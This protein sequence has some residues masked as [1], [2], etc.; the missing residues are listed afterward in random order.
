MAEQNNRLGYSIFHGLEQND[1]LIEI[2]DALLHNCFLQLFHIGNI[3]PK[4][5]YAEDSLRFA[6]LLSKSV[7]VPLSEMHHSLAQEIVTLLNQLIPGDKDVE[8][9]MGSVLASTS[10]YLGLQHS[11]PNYQEAGIL[12]RLSTETIKDYLR[13]PSE[14]NKYFLSSQKDVF[15]HMVEDSFFSYSG[16]TSMGKS[17]V[18]R[19]FIREL[20]KNGN[21]CNFAVIIPTK[22]LINE[23]SKE[24]LDNLGCLLREHDYRLVISAGAAILQDQNEHK[25][26]FVM[27]PE[28]LMYQLIGYPDIPIHYLFIDEAQKI[29]DKEGRSAFYYQI[30]EM[31]YR[32]EPHPHIIFASPHIPNPSVYLE[33]V[34]SVITGE[35]THYI[36]TYTPVSQEKFL[37]DIRAHNLGYYNHLTQ[38]LNTLASFDPSMTLQSF[39]I[40]LG[41]GKKNLVY[42]NAKWKVVDFAR[43]YASALPAIYDPDLI[44]LAAEIREEIHDH[45]YLADTIEKG[46]AY[47]VGYLPTSIRLRIEELFRKRD[48][49]VHM[50]FCTSTLLEGVNLPADN[51]F[52]TD[53]KNGTHPMSAVEFRNLIGRVGRL[54]YSLYGNAFLVCLPN[55]ST[56]PQNYVTLLKKDIELQMLSVDTISDNEKEYIR[57]CLKAGKTKLEK[58]GGQTDEDFALMRKTANILLRDIM[59]DRKGRISREFESVITDADIILIKKQFT[60]RQ[61]EPDDDINLSLDQISALA[62]AIANGLDY[63]HVNMYGYASFQDTLAFLEQLCDVFDW[64]TYEP[65]TLGYVKDGKHSKLKFYTTLL[66]QWLTGNGIKYLIDQAICYKRGKNIYIKGESVPFVEGAEHNNKVIEDTLN[67]AN[68]IILF[69]LSNYFMRVST[70]LKKYKKR[71][72][73]TNDW[74]EYVEYG[75]TNRICILLQKNGF[76][77]EIATYIQKHEDQ[78]VERTD[79]GIKLR[80]SVLRCPRKSVQEEAKAVYNNIPELFINE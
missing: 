34:P 69:R 1:Y 32:K 50:I 72:Y 13:I 54:Q 42:C 70:E 36:S 23:V 24:M 48:G 40:E 38:E 28:R 11:I 20:I 56:E 27:T 8:Y 76:S 66:T 35:R 64:E 4:E 49:G 53:Y 77:S 61:N 65:G 73:L 75:T 44:T 29:S 37:I 68:D 5:V 74:Y 3:A 19:T 59:L 39:L 10:N 17:F 43:E 45:Y 21:N 51:L 7:Q 62:N 79:D 63:P 6:D 31:L 55:E 41:T 80:I 12:E 58:L 52:I 18:M 15:D 30:V 67:V 25:Y 60:G 16:P 33:L 22:A 46:V 2:Y 9:V 57:D 71:D 47:H 14:D 78:Y 26:I